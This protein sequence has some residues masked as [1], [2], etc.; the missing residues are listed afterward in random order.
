MPKTRLVILGA[1]GSIGSSALDV[2]RSQ[3]H[4]FDVVGMSCN[5][6][7]PELEQLGQEFNCSRLWALG[8]RSGDERA[9]LD[10]LRSQAVDAVL[11]AISGSA[12]LVPTL[13]AMQ[14]SRRILLAS[15]EVMVMAGNLVDQEARR[16]GVDIIPIDSEH[17]AVLQCWRQALERDRDD[18]VEQ[19]TLTASGGPFWQTPLEQL[20]AITPAQACAHPQWSMGAKISIDSATMMNKALEVIEAAHLF[21]LEP[22]SIKV[23][24]HPQAIVHALVRY[25]DGAEV[26]QLGRPDMRTAIAYALAYPERITLPTPRLDLAQLQ[27]LEFY[28]VD[29]SRFPAL[30]LGYQA[31]RSAHSYAVALNAANEVA[32]AAFLDH[33]IKFT[34]IVPLVASALDQIAPTNCPDLETILDV[35]HKARQFCSQQLQ[36]IS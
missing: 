10:F 34:D 32:V 3:A 24:I 7:L 30:K 23:L 18:A 26:A 2:L 6:S 22:E 4:S 9:M 19:I 16:L 27:K 5:H 1:T 28:Q 8:K 31:L 14:A 12:S 20:S 11:V 25:Q 29:S 17:N 35:D 33:S 15:K 13:A 21:H 36:R